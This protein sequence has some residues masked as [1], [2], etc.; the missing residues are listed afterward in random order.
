M[1]PMRTT[2]ERGYG[3]GHQQ[4]RERWRP[5]VEAGQARCAQPICLMRNR[6]I[7]P[8]TPWALGHNDTRTAYIGPVHERCNAADGGRRS[9]Q[10][11]RTT[12]WST[13]RRW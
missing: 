12:G 3:H 10:R 13:S 7:R 6:W 5:T 8:G 9:K 2:T 4:E 11:T 1:K